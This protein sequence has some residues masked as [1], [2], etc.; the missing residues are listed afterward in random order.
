MAL[1]DERTVLERGTTPEG[2]IQLQ[3]RRTPQGELAYEII[4]N[5][6]F[7]MASYNRESERAL[8]TLALEGRRDGSAQGA[9]G[10]SAGW[11]A[12]GTELAPPEGPPL[13]V[14]VGGLG[15]GYT[16]QAV[17]AWPR[18]AAVDV[19]EIDQTLIGWNPRHFGHLNGQALDDARVRLVCADMAD[20]LATA[21]GPYQAV[22]LDVDNGPHWLARPENARLYGV[23]GLR[24]LRGLLGDG[25]VLTV[26]SA[27]PDAAFQGRLRRV[28]GE[29][30]ALRVAETD[31]WGYEAEP[32]IYRAVAGGP[33]PRSD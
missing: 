24:R 32:V 29:V 2:D 14:L 25:G 17:L 23:R 6:V 4:L 30:E 16:L 11:R 3:T 8:A 21:T 27:G 7:I 20:W 33:I 12:H 26:W 9:P 1:H 22:C 19:V 28:F 10:E 13:R 31:P 5:G 15:M 18:V